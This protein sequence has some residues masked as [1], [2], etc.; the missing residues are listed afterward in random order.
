MI[1]LEY[2]T[3]NS[4][5]ADLCPKP[6]ITDNPLSKKSHVED[7]PEPV[8]A[9]FQALTADVDAQGRWITFSFPVDF[10][11]SLFGPNQMEKA[12]K[13]QTIGKYRNFVM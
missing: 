13:Y 12:V 1:I 11:V 2:S 7:F 3:C 10:D 9:L 8:P 6:N 5:V 4:R